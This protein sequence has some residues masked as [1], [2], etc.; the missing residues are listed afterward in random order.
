MPRRGW[1]KQVPKTPFCVTP[2]CGK[3]VAARGV[4]WACY[5]RAR[6]AGNIDKSVKGPPVVPGRVRLPADTLR[7][8]LEDLRKWVP[9]SQIHLHKR[10]EIALKGADHADS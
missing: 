6:R 10:I 4:C 1:R 5:N 7:V 8:L 3:P 9:D 2:K